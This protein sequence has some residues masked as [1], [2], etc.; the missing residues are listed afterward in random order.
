MPKQ[1]FN[2]CIIDNPSKVLKHHH[3][4]LFR[5]EQSSMDEPSM[6]LSIPRSSDLDS[7]ILTEIDRSDIIS[8]SALMYGV[9]HTKKQHERKIFNTFIEPEKSVV[10][11]NIDEPHDLHDICTMEPTKK[12]SHEQELLPCIHENKSVYSS[13]STNEPTSA[14]YS[15]SSISCGNED[16]S[17][18]T[19]HRSGAFMQDIYKIISDT[20]S[21]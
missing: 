2:M 3:K 10:V 1:R 18:Y 5:D 7:T 19:P 14:V 9:S 4:V 17:E 20:R 8:F 6:M 13:E 11:H 16:V 21:M 15:V 12:H